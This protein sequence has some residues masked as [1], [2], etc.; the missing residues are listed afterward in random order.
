MALATDAAAAPDVPQ[1]VADGVW[2]IPGAVGGGRQPD[3]NTVVFDTG[4][5]LVVIDTGRHP[6]HRDA[7]LA[8]AAERREPIVAVINSHWHLDHV[9]GNP[10]L[11]AAYPG[12]KVYASNAI[13]EALTGFLARSAAQ[14]R[15]LMAAGKVPPG[16]VGELKADLA[17]TDNGEALKPDIVVTKS[18]SARFGALSLRFNLAPNAA[19]ARDVWVYDEPRRIVAAGDLVT[20]PAAFLDTACP[21]G[22]SA[23]L[24]AIDATPFDTLVPGHGAPMTHDEF[25]TYRRA[26]D[27]LVDCA[28]TDA[29]KAACAER[30]VSDLGGLLP[31][32]QTAMARGMSGYYVEQV[33]RRPAALPCGRP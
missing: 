24:A 6:A 29:S 10:A 14:A 4:K 15:E 21:A 19:T 26:F 22:W 9:S 8:F 28:A 18:G 1:R 23:A 20:L 2:L 31:S 33:L 16:S 30:W 13:D 11:R 12:L 17:T 3:G 32:D 5:A 27:G 7:I 25:R